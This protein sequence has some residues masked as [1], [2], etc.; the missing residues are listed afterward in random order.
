MEKAHYQFSVEET[1]ST[2]RTDK[3]QGL[4]SEE[5]K[6]RL[7]ENGYNEFKKVKHTTI[8]QKFLAQF[9]SFLIIVLLLAAVIS[10]VTGWMNGEGITDA[11]IILVI[12]VINAIIGVMQETKA[13]KSLDALEKMSAP[14]CKVVR[15]GKTQ[16]IESREL[17]V[18]DLVII[19]TGDSIPADLRL[20]EAVNLK[21]QESALTG[22]SV[23]VEKHTDTISETVP[24]GDRQ[25]LVFSSCGVT[26]G[27]GKGVVVAT[28]YDTEVGKIASMIM[29]VPQTQTPMQMRLDQLGKVLAI[30]ALVVCFIIFVIGL[31]Y[32]NDILTMFMTAV[33][34]AVAAIPEGLPAVSTVVLAIGVQRLAKQNAIIRNLP[35]VE[36]L[37]CTNVICSDK[38]GTLTQ[39]KMTVTHLF[40]DGKI[41]TRGAESETVTR[42]VE[43]AMLVN[44]ATINRTTTP[45]TYNGDPTETALIDLGQHYE[46]DKEQLDQLKP[47]LL[48]IPFDSERKRMSSI[49]KIGENSYLVA[50]KGGLDEMLACCTHIFK[51]GK[52]EKLS[53]SNLKEIHAANLQMASDALRVLAVG[54]K[55]IG[56]LPEEAD[57]KTVESE[58]IFLGMVGM[59]DP[60]R[61]EVAVAVEQCI[62]AGIK[63]VMITGDHKLTAAAIAKSLGILKANDRVLTG[64]DV[65]NLSE[66][67]LVN[68]VNDVSVFARVAPEHKVRIVKAYQA[69]GNVVAMTG[70]GVNDA[71]ALKLADIG[72]AMGITGTDVSKEA[73][74]AVLADDNFATI[75]AAVKEGRRIYANILK[76]IRFMVATNLGEIIVLFCA[77]IFNFPLPLLPIQLLWVNLVGDSLPALALSVEPA[78]KDIMRQRPTDAKQGI[79]TRQFIWQIALQSLII[80]GLTLWAYLI[81]LNT[82]VEVA[83]TMTFAVLVFT[84]MTLIL[85]IRAGHH[86]ATN[87]LFA[88]K[89]LWGAILIVCGLMFSVMLIPELQTLFKIVNL[90][91]VQWWWI[92]GL[93]LAALVIN[94][95]GKVFIRLFD[96][97]T[98]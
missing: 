47:R 20:T 74:D 76:S 2:H 12:I 35:S 7:A 65:E 98:V 55:E 45:V 82:S 6:K 50:V 36:T 96:K 29:S 94:E 33:S 21:V 81:G 24:I 22:E 48:E 72:V 53:A 18:G 92:G 4:S 44:D 5:A 56:K 1:F 46:I 95:I 60:P 31:L 89:Y 83:R 54:Y 69:N 86:F 68:T 43:T 34:L 71:P 58:L 49:H 90:T 91:S 13:E 16:V 14:H 41:E 28:G 42:L 17:V 80:S 77:V 84:Q 70:D 88:N 32:G 15:D 51:N 39:N 97:K 73:A 25:N 40:C 93:S 87:G 75:V 37:G 78:E 59:I 64:T 57:V 30:V 11:L 79:F 27:R 67:E 10:G 52:I 38:T 19:E 26:Y 61:I 8:L 66:T 62:T 23:P 85:S 63:P 3:T 9:K